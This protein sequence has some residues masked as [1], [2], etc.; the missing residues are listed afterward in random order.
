MMPYEILTILSADVP[1]K[2]QQEFSKKIQDLVKKENGKILSESNL[3]TKKFAYPIHDQQTGTYLS[4][5]CQLTPD[6]VKPIKKQLQ[7]TEEIIKLFIFKT[8]EPVK[9]KAKKPEK[10]K[11]KL[12]KMAETLKIAE[13]EKTEKIAVE[14]KKNIK[15]KPQKIKP[16]KK[17]II[18]AEIENEEDR[19]KKLDEKL[20]ELLKE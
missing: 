14:P 18:A 13:P 8:A 9:E 12:K 15:K 5:T 6:S 10:I 1:E 20:D 17:P 7:T 11:P 2:G 19:L 4:I 3:G 16:E